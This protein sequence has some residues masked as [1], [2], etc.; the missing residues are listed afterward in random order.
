M[1]GKQRRKYVRIEAK[2][3]YLQITL[4]YNEEAKL[5]LLSMG[6]PENEIYIKP[7]C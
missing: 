1:I 5:R 6:I 3:L 2:Q 7:N 4:I